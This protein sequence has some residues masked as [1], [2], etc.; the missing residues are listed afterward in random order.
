VTLLK[1]KEKCGV[2]CVSCDGT[3]YTFLEGEPVNFSSRQVDTKVSL[4]WLL[5]VL[6]F[7]QKARVFISDEVEDI[8]EIENHS[9]VTFLEKEE[10]TYVLVKKVGDTKNTMYIQ[11]DCDVK[12]AAVTLKGCKDYD[13]IVGDRKITTVT[14]TAAD[15]TKKSDTTDRVCTCLPSH[16][17][18]NEYVT[19]GNI[20]PGLEESKQTSLK[21]WTSTSHTYQNFNPQSTPDY[22]NVFAES[23]EFIIFKKQDIEEPVYETLDDVMP[24]P[25]HR[26]EGGS[27]TGKSTTKEDS[28][29]RS[30]KKKISLADQP[31]EI[32]MRHYISEKLAKEWNKLATFLGLEYS[33]SQQIQRDC[34]TTEDRC[35]TV[36]VYW[37]QGK[38]TDSEPRT[39]DVLLRKL[40]LLGRKEL[41]I[42]IRDMITN[43]TLGDLCHK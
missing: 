19:L 1:K 29:L 41:A 7:P 23:R 10:Q 32:H 25:K 5:K 2:E 30:G 33:V 13:Q 22:Y 8:Q 28:L 17:R 4:P 40:K 36:L 14:D 27:S 18:G 3:S 9:E 12:V 26:D 39:W 34:E 35:F 37:L 15:E 43:G 42:K 24:D 16:L 11:E 20:R 6:Q 21:E 38:G 31:S